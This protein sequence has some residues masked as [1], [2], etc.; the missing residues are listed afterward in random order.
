MIYEGG[1]DCRAPSKRQTNGNCISI[2]DG[3]L[4]GT[5]VPSKIKT[6]IWTN[7]YV[8]LRCPLLHKKEDLIVILKSIIAYSAF[9][10][11]F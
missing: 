11:V 3:F 9:N 5:T 7:E 10:L 2:T 6:I 8:A 1:A 4:L